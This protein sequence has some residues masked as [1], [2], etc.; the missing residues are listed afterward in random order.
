VEDTTLVLADG[1]RT[2]VHD[3]D[4]PTVDVGGRRRPAVLVR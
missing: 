3:D 1:A 2:L 4:W